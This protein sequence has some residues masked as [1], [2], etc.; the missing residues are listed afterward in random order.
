[1]KLGEFL[2]QPLFLKE[3]AMGFL[4][5]NAY[6]DDPDSV[7][8]ILVEDSSIEVSVSPDFDFRMKYLQEEG[9]EP[10][11][12]VEIAPVNSKFSVSLEKVYKKVG[13]ATK[14][15]EDIPFVLI[16]DANGY[17]FFVED[18]RHTNAFYKAVGKAVFDKFD[19]RQSFIV[20]SDYILPEDVVRAAYLGIPVIG[21]LKGT[22]DLAVSVADSLK[23]TVFVLTLE[24]VDVYTHPSRIQ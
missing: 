18:V 6:I 9:K 7:E 16:A 4:Y 21:S 20:F 11:E 1:M 15:S 24:G 22:T 13:D 5:S 10:L 12:I 2:T 8:S 14:E 23:V 19:L 17:N 3:L